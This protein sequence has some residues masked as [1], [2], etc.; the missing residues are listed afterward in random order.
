MPWAKHMK[1]IAQCNPDSMGDTNAYSSSHEQPTLMLQRTKRSTAG[2]GGAI[3]QPGKVGDALVQPQQT[4]RQWVALPDNAPWNTLAPTPHCKRKV[5]QPS[6]KGRSCK[7]IASIVF[8]Y[9]L[10][11]T[12][13]NAVAE[14]HTEDSGVEPTDVTTGPQPKFQRAE[15]G[16]R[17]GFQVQFPMQP[18]F[19]GT[20]TLN[21]YK[22]AQAKYPVHQ[23]A[24]ATPPQAQGQT[25]ASRATAQHASQQPSHAVPRDS[26]VNGHSSQLTSRSRPQ[27]QPL[28]T[29]PEVPSTS[30]IPDVAASLMTLSGPSKKLTGKSSLKPFQA[31]QRVI[32]PSPNAFQTNDGTSDDLSKPN[33]AEEPHKSDG[34]AWASPEDAAYEDT[35]GHSNN[36]EIFDT[37]RDDNRWSFPPANEELNGVGRDDLYNSHHDDLHLGSEEMDV[38]P[39]EL[40]DELNNH[41]GT[42]SP[43]QHASPLP[44]TH[45]QRSSSQQQPPQL[46]LH[47]QPIASSQHI[48]LEK[49]VPW[50][51]AFM[52][53][54]PTPSQQSR[55][56]GAPNRAQDPLL[57]HPLGQHQESVSSNQSVLTQDH[58]AWS[59]DGPQQHGNEQIGMDYN[60]NASHHSQNCCPC[61]PSPE[62]LQDMGNHKRHRSKKPRSDVAKHVQDDVNGEGNCSGG[63][64]NLVS[65]H[66]GKYSKTAKVDVVVQP[67]TLAF[68]GPLWCKVL[69]EAKGRMRL[70]VAMEVPFL[71]CEMAINGICMEILVK[72][73]IKYEEDGLELEASFY[74]E[75][76]RSMATIL[77]NNM[78]TFC[79]EIKKTAIHI[80][81]F[82]YCLYPPE[83]I[84]DDGKCIEFVKKKAVQL[85]EGAQYLHGDVDS[86]G[87][88]S[89]FAHP[90]L[91][92]ICLAVYYC[93][94]SKS[95]CQFVKFQ[96][97]VPDRALVLKHGTIKNK[98]LCGE[99]VND[100]YHNL[101]SLV[102]QVW[103]N[104]YHG[105][106]LER[107][108]QEWA[109][110]GMMGYSTRE[111]AQ[112]ETDEWQVVL[113]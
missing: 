89:N 69:D 97:S 102:D 18:S 35:S 23:T 46:H 34:G 80:V 49:S 67:T 79:S 66:C 25:T 85:L 78:Q 77:F 74:P 76:K 57:P 29:T 9:M 38:R 101:S 2:Q 64:L 92:K 37:G 22:Q 47:M 44:Q 70:Y 83:N 15:P 8:P 68:F 58:K 84:E 86:L 33:S 72:M 24:K 59:N 94:S 21:E 48:P 112:L 26:I 105:N 55:L 88:T 5:P 51:I 111:A 73:V 108:L 36:D 104:D 99:E 42:P 30:S 10:V 45:S 109:R 93:N 16:T 20:Q 17:F 113:D 100:A 19:I 27:P 31:A 110:A 82:E 60:I 32:H 50:C 90:A 40:D 3:V 11:Y 53:S 4:P 28:S 7:V 52:Q 62:T 96:M 103:H 61:P 106:K 65:K 81:P 63:S 39:H 13:Q 56:Q 98:T 14:M 1:K 91:R 107:M 41:F 12:K 75:H 87:R 43:Q 71:C 6:Q 95:L 54:G